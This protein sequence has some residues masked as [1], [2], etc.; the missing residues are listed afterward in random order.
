AGHA[1]VNNA[2]PTVV[3]ASP[4]NGSVFGANQTVPIVVNT[5]DSDGTVQRVEYFADDVKVG[6]A[7][8]SPFSFSWSNAPLGSHQLLARAIDDRLGFKDSE[9]VFVGVVNLAPTA[10]LT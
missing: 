4:S 5:M 9:P 1:T 10:A 3:I 6:Q 8:V 7:V 2:R